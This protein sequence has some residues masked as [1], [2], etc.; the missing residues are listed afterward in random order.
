VV[1]V[2]EVDDQSPFEKAGKS[3]VLVSFHGE[4]IDNEFTLIPRAGDKP[5]PDVKHK[6]GSGPSVGVK[7]GGT[8]V[9]VGLPDKS[10]EQGVFELR[11]QLVIEKPQAKTFISQATVHVRSRRRAMRLFDAGKPYETRDLVRPTVGNPDHYATAPIT[12]NSSLGER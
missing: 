2:I 11:V 10:A 8:T 12:G 4:I 5:N 9:D 3:K 6:P 7:L 1:N